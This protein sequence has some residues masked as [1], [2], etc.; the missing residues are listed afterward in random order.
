LERR[1]RSISE[2]ERGQAG[3]RERLMLIRIFEEL[4]RLGYEGGFDAVRRYACKWRREHLAMTADAY[5]LL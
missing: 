2:E 4:R 3:A 5:V 1:S